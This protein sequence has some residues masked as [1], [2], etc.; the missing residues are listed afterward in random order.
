VDPP[1]LAPVGP[2]RLPRRRRRRPAAKEKQEG[3]EGGGDGKGRRGGG[4][5]DVEGSI[6]T[7]ASSID[8][9]PLVSA[10]STSS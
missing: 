1:P 6:A 3:G 7:N 9:S 5:G 4:L 2:R 10:L 8:A